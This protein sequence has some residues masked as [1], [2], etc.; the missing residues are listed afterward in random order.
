MN[1][2][3]IKT[4]GYGELMPIASNDTVEG[5]LKNRRVEITIQSTIY[6]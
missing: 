5:R 4:E 1:E 2:K 6:K 3:M